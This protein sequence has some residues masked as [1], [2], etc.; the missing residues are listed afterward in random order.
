MD[1]SLIRT[2]NV[3]DLVVRLLELHRQDD[4][5]YILPRGQ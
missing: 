5:T 2:A 1:R 3:T 4:K